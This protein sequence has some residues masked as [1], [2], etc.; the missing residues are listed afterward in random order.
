M[1]QLPIPEFDGSKSNHMRL[2]G[3]SKQCH[4]TIEKHMFAKK[5][6]RGMRIEAAQLLRN[7]MQ[8]IDSIVQSIL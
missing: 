5:G 2:M 1:F 4:Q 6:F 8:E 3:L 7:E